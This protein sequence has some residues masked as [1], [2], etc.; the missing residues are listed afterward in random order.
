M[1]ASKGHCIGIDLGTTYS[2]VGVWQNDRVEI[3]ANDQGDRTTASWVSFTDT[4]RLI[5]GAAKQQATVN[6]QQTIFDA[7]RLIGRKFS[8]SVVQQDMRHWPFKVVAGPHD[9]P[10]IEVTYLGQVH[11]FSPEEISAMVLSKM[12]QIAEVYLG[13][14]VKNAVVTVPAYFN[15]SQR[16]STKDAGKIAGLNIM[17]I[18]NEPTAAAIAYGLDKKGDKKKV[19]IFD[20]GGGTFDVS[21]LTLENGLFEVLATAGDTHLGGEDFDNRMVKHF[22]AQFKKETGSD[23]NTN[24][25]ALRK[26]RA[27]CE[28]TKRTLSTN[29]EANIEIDSLCDGNDFYTKC[30]RALFEQLCMDLFKNC[31]TPVEKV[32]KDSKVDKK[33]V[34][35]IVLVGGST[36]I[37]KVQQLLQDMFNGK[38]LNKSINPDEAVAYGASIQ[39]AILSGSQNKVLLDILLLDVTPISLGIET[40]GGVMST[41]IKRNTTVP[42]KKSSIFTTTEDNQRVVTIHVYEGERQLVKDNHSLG[43]FDLTGIPP[44]PRGKPQINVTFELDANGILHVSAVDKATG[45]SG[46]IT[47]TNDAGRLSADEVEK[48]VRDAEKF[49]E[50][51]RKAMEKVTVKNEIEEYAYN[52]KQCTDEPTVKQKLTVSE[53]NELNEAADEALT[54]IESNPDATLEQM[55]ETKKKIERKCM[56]IMGKIY[57]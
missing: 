18:I 42:C 8:D 55:K 54:W 17:R 2:C 41:L 15:D 56:P 45:S 46:S 13:E 27:A 35:E 4:E 25:K 49:A 12:K 32:L 21:L 23:V 52:I 26:L 20:L 43:L 44:V 29:T 39:A 6:P 9:K 31:M 3:I 38:E 14:T 22:A 11:T 40:E 53:R 10:L 51:D 47:I 57:S 50:E 37:P 24:P 1:E 36:R 7:K 19:L 48:M 30:T 28:R 16:Q 33:E 34:D 5:G